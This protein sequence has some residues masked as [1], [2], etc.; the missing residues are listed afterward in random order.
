MARPVI[1]YYGKDDIES[2]V[3]Q[4]WM[5]TV[6]FHMEIKDRFS[7]VLDAFHVYPETITVLALAEPPARL[8]EFANQIR[9][10]ADP[11][12]HLV[13]ILAERP[14][15]PNVSATEVFPRPLRLSHVAK[16]IQATARQ[17]A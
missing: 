8:I 13:F 15:E 2:D 9:A 6:G 12:C 7:Q 3:F 16:R 14:F 11:C 17:H 1:I 4:S 10:S 5:Q